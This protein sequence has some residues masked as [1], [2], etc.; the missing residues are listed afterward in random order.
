LA[1]YAAAAAIEAHVFMP[2]DVP[3]ANRVECE[4]HGAQVTLVEGT[5]GDCARMV[6]EGKE[7]QGWFDMTTLKEPFRVEG[8]KTMAYEV[9]EQ[10]GGQVPQGI[11]Y[12]TGGGV[13]LIGMWKAFDEMEMLGWIGPERPR[14]V[15]V[16]AEGCAPIVKAWDEG[17]RT[18]EAWPN[19]ET[20]A[21]GL[22]VPKP[23]GDYL[24]LDILKKSSGIA[25][26]VT[27]EEILE[28]VRDWARTDGVFAAPEGAAA[29]AAY[30]KL[31]ARRF[32]S[33]GDVVVLFNTGSGLKYLDVIGGGG[34]RAKAPA[35]RQI[36]GIIGP[37]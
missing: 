13:G 25:V 18:A 34:K 16:Q 17:R 15:A 20:I 12:P 21:A 7:Q 2:Q 11:V 6:S 35:S 24:I 31:L 4:I 33:P 10:L 22:R 5:I 30:R 32:F 36:G 8:K 23:Y 19:P 28:A 14:M 29:L 1:A 9:M 3:L 37:Y 26:A 27:D